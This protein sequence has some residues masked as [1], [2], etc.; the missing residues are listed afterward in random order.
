MRY[1]GDDQPDANDCTCR[2]DGDNPRCPFHC[3]PDEDPRERGD[4]D[5]VEYGDPRDE[6]DDRLTRN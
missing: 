2:T 4:D 5:G 1:P 6:M 3:V